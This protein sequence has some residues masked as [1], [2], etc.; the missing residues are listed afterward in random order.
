[1]SNDNAFFGTILALMALVF[2]HPIVAVFIFFIGVL[3]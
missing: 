2:G 1:M 3:V